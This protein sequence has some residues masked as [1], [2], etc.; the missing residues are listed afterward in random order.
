M[1]FSPILISTLAPTVFFH[2][3]FLGHAER[4]ADDGT[5]RDGIRAG[6][7]RAGLDVG[8]HRLRASGR[9][10]IARSFHVAS[11]EIQGAI[12]GTQFPAAEEAPFLVCFSLKNSVCYN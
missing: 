7:V 2:L 8:Y 6:A 10:A 9:V 5:V 1:K 3:H 11:G 12:R 4:D